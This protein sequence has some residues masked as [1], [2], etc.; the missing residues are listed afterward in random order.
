MPTVADKYLVCHTDSWLIVSAC[1]V[2]KNPYIS[3]KEL[4][5]LYVYRIR[6]SESS[7]SHK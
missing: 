5:I 2:T 4:H 7:F 1:K 3:Q 6:N